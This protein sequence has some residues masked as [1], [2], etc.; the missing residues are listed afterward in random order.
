MSPRPHR[1]YPG[2]LAA[3]LTVLLAVAWV[4]FAPEMLGGQASYVIINGNSMEPLYHRGDLVILR[5]SDQAEAG[6]IF[7][8]RYP[9]LGPVIH[10]IVAREGGRFIMKGDHNSWTDGYHPQFDDLI[11]KAFIHLPGVGNT[12][13]WL[14]QP[15]RFAGLVAIMAGLLMFGL[16]L[17]PSQ[18]KRKT[19]KWPQFR[20]ELPQIPPSIAREREGYLFALSLLLFASIALGIYAFITPLSKTIED[21]IGYVNSVDYLYAAPSNPNVYTGGIILPGEPVFTQLN[22]KLKIVMDYAI[23]SAQPLAVDGFYNTRAVVSEPTGWKQTISLQANTPFKDNAYQGSVI[24]DI[25]SIQ[26][27]IESMT[28]LTGLNRAY[29]S[30]SVIS[31]ITASGSIGGRA[32]QDK[33][34]PSLDFILDPTELYLVQGDVNGADPL[35][36]KQADS[37]LG[38]RMVSNHLSL[39]GMEI[40]VLTARILAIIGLL[41]SIAGIVILTLP[42]YQEAKKDEL[43]AIHLKYAPLL[44]K[45]TPAQSKRR[46][47]SAKLVEID[48]MADLA[49]LAQ[50]TGQMVFEQTVGDEHHFLVF[51]D[52]YTY[53]YILQTPI[54]DEPVPEPEESQDAGASDDI[55]IENIDEA[56]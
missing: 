5:Q 51:S 7:A 56:E 42:S 49:R 20:F 43:A 38:V 48:S 34:S 4:I 29:Y 10:R 55:S 27:M 52:P 36:W 14:R 6:D 54:K 13:K 53:R 47:A 41:L 3:F 35:H 50:N 17:D 21:N 15:S 2:I 1:K 28:S 32:Y 11:G 37:T 30:V 12:V 24:L 44:V 8:Y 22:C 45:I 16:V 18:K 9:E 19:I 46:A 40:P 33:L 23:K 26:K 25:C 39:F 31:E